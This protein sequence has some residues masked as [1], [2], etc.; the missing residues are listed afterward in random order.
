MGDY[1]LIGGEFR[2]PEAM[3]AMLDIG[4]QIKFKSH[5]DTEIGNNVDLMAYQNQ[6]E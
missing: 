6:R 5:C 1:L 3:P 4:G 2:R